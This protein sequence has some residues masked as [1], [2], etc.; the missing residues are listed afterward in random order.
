MGATFR[1]R[2]HRAEDK[3]YRSQ[4]FHKIFQSYLGADRQDNLVILIATFERGGVIAR[5]ATLRF[6]STL[7]G[8]ALGFI[9]MHH[10][11]ANAQTVNTNR[12]PIP[13]Y[14][15][16]LTLCGL[17]FNLYNY[18]PRQFHGRFSRPPYHMVSVRY[19]ANIS[20][21]TISKGVVALDNALHNTAGPI[22][23][24]AHSQGAQVV[25]H[26]LR[27]HAN[28][29]TAPSPDRLTFLLTGNPLRSS[30]G[31][32]IGRH[33]FGNTIGE[34]T[35]TTSRWTVIDVARKYDGWAD[36]PTDDSNRQA[37]KYARLGMH[38][39]HVHYDE[40]DL[41]DPTHMVWKVGTTTFVLTH[42]VPPTLHNR[43]DRS[44]NLF[45]SQ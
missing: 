5:Q 12:L 29:P 1:Q 17:N 3:V 22:I 7:T 44:R 39:Y 30:G 14:G 2:L 42:E 36:W 8:I 27:E 19:P 10:Q 41:D 26:W 43:N 18:M 4:F 40:V 24:L 23:V 11:P 28:D 9:S 25:S 33:E 38:S 45:A 32:G 6:I 34:P 13:P 21:N 35:P 37:V 15:T 31:H 16:V 20:R